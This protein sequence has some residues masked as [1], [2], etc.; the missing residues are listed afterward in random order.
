MPRLKVMTLNL[1]GL[2]HRWDARRDHLIAALQAE[3][4]DVLL[5][6]EVADRGWR[7]NQ[8][9]ELATMTGYALMYQPVQLFFPWPTVATGLAILSRFPMANPRGI[10]LTPPRGVLPVGPNERRVAQRVELSLDTMSVVVYNTHFPLDAA[11]RATAARR[12]WHEITGEDAVLVVAGGDFNARPDEDAVRFL[13][14]VTTLESQ[15]GA[16]TD[17]WV[18]AGIGDAETYPTYAPQARIDYIFYQAE[19]SI[20]VQEAKVIGRSPYELSDHAGVVATFS[21]SPTRQPVMPEEV[22][23]VATLEPV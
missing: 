9:A 21:I 3:E 12:L 4:I 13:Q 18:T 11:A 17:A 5:L 22:E 14:G 7:L 10:E 20:I 23:P 15:C 6:Q 16:L 19:P 8:A 2:H 1:W